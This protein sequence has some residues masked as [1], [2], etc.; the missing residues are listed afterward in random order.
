MDDRRIHNQPC[1]ELRAVERGV[2][3]DLQV[4]A[5]ST[6]RLERRLDRC[7]GHL[8]AVYH[9]LVSN[10]RIPRKKRDL[11]SLWGSRIPRRGFIVGLLLSSGI[12]VRR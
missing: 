12:L 3:D 4:D 5:A 2:C 9:R 6:D 1:F 7:S 10:R 8:A 11:F